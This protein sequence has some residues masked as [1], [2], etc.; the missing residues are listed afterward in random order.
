MQATGF[1]PAALDWQKPACFQLHHTYLRV[2]I[3][4]LVGKVRAT[5]NFMMFIK[6][7][8]GKQ[9]TRNMPGLLS[10]NL[11]RSHYATFDSDSKKERKLN[12]DG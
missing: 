12:R 1:E 2:D 10:A 3:F 4:H 6:H 5:G 11:E 8:G 9:K 7:L